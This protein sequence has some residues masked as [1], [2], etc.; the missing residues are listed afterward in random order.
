MP[1]SI[2]LSPFC[3][4]NAV[5]IPPVE[6]LD[7][8]YIALTDTRKSTA[9]APN[10]TDTSRGNGPD[11]AMV[12][13][14]GSLSS[15]RSLNSQSY[16]RCSGGGSV[17]HP[18]ALDSGHAVS[19]ART[20]RWEYDAHL[21]ADAA[22]DKG[23]DTGGSDV[24][25]V[26]PT[27]STGDGSAARPAR[28]RMYRVR[29]YDTLRSIARDTLGDAYRARQILELNRNLI[30]DP[31]HLTVGQLLELPVDARMNQSQ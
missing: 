2:P 11:S 12:S 3:I 5:I 15:V 19:N 6:D 21:G 10:R 7:P 28:Q 30:D 31:S 9:A 29:Q 24:R 22:E 13:D 25:R 8:A 17:A 27:R 16:S 4:G 14:E 1:T 23:P 18:D 20:E 26:V